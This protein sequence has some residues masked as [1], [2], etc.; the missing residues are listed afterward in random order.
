MS[1]PQPQ[2]IDAAQVQA[3]IDQQLQALQSR[4]EE[5]IQSLREEMDAK[6]SAAAQSAVAQLVQTFVPDHAGGPGTTIAE[7][8]SQYE[9]AQQHAARE[10]ASHP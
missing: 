5:E 2:W 8:W 1:E 6:V 9:Q 3:L 10:A 4:H 7:T